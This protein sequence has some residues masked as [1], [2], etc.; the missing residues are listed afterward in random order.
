MLSDKVN[1]MIYS[2]LRSGG[3]Q[4]KLRRVFNVIEHVHF[5]VFLQISKREVLLDWNILEILIF[6][7]FLIIFDLFSYY[8][9]Y[10]YDYYLTRNFVNERRSI[11]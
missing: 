9:Y 8:D 2:A 11:K 10:Y 1:K 6:I 7:R 5:N 3:L 4:M